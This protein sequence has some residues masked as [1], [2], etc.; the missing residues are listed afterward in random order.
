MR[1]LSGLAHG[2]IRASVQP[3]RFA[4]DRSSASLQSLQREKLASLMGAIDGTAFARQHGL[5][6]RTSWEDFANNVPMT[7]YS[8]WAEPIA[9]QREQPENRLI[10]SPVARYQPTS[11]STSAV[12]WIPYTRRFL[13]ELDA[14]ICPW[15]S[16]MYHR[17]PGIRTGA[18]YWSLSWVP[19]EMRAHTTGHIN[20]DMK[21]LSFGKR[22]L[23]SSTQ[24]VPDAIS[25]AP[26]SDDSLF[27]TVTY[28]AARS[29]LT[30]MSIWSPTFA[31][32]LLEKLSLWRKEVAAVLVYGH[33]CS[34]QGSLGYLP[35]PESEAAADLLLN[36]DGEL[37]AAFFVNLWPRLSLISAWDT[38]ASA[39][40]A[41]RLQ[42]LLP[43]ADFQGKG[44]WSTEGVV[45]IPYKDDFV[46]AAGSHVYEFEDIASK[47][48]LPPWALEAGQE[49]TP[50]L[51]TGSGLLRYRMNDVLKVTGH[52]GQLPA[53]RFLGRNDGADIAGEKISTILA[54]RLLDGLDWPSGLQPVALLAAD[55]GCKSGRPAYV[56]M[57]EADV[58]ISS[59]WRKRHEKSLGQQLEAG[60]LEHFHYLVARNLN[61]LGP[62]RCICHPEARRHFLE[63]CSRRGM[64]EGNIKVEALRHWTGRLPLDPP[65]A[66]ASP[67]LSAIS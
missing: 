34:H 55:E 65:V 31:L 5:S 23:V 22:W 7:N 42:T 37:S 62:V 47:Q 14:A 56:L 16:D 63:A 38:A 53:L 25:L 35:C 18:H 8:D 64:I 67:A 61:Q 29:D 50:I 45:T 41:Q 24:A 43:Q 4:Y 26:S 51:S 28:L 48:V 44:L 32:G 20:D 19:T 39:P 13:K 33:W 57:V 27:A 3:G 30:A 46:L 11:G 17:Y 15:I 40:W 54:Q 1:R 21:L 52:Q 12:K 2:L 59:Y 49:V 36:W 10:D 6:A 9:A 60:L 58:A 66:V